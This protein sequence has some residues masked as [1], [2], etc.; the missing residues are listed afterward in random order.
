MACLSLT[1]YVQAYPT[2]GPLGSLGETSVARCSFAAANAV[3]TKLQRTVVEPLRTRLSTLR[4][5][6][7]IAERV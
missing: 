4:L 2:H 7:W 1:E 6:Q 5:P 3:N